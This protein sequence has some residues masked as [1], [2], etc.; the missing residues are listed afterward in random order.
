MDN[1]ISR[2]GLTAALFQSSGFNGHEWAV[3]MMNKVGDYN[4]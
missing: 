4:D 2:G 1:A 3:W